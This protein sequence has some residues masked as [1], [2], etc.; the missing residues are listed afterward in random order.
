MSSEEERIQ[1]I[2]A[3]LKNDPTNRHLVITLIG[4]GEKIIPYLEKISKEKDIDLRIAALKIAGGIGKSGISILLQALNAYDWNV[5]LAAIRFLG[6]MGESAK[7]SAPKLLPFLESKD[8]YVRKKVL[9]ALLKINADASV[10]LPIIPSLIKEKDKEIRKRVIQLLENISFESEKIT[11]LIDS[12][13][14]ILIEEIIYLFEEDSGLGDIYLYEKDIDLFF[15]IFRK[16]NYNKHIPIFCNIIV[17]KH[18]SYNWNL[19]FDELFP[20]LKNGFDFNIVASCL[21]DSIDKNLN[22]KGKVKDDLILAIEKRLNVDEIKI[23]K[24]ILD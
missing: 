15:S 18:N 14:N 5:R 10:L 9:W 22:L 2:F 11:S 1:E 19:H 7:I 21:K 6:R 20:R 3:A 16:A 24:L 23:L 13:F 12:I 17:E 8:D 4:F